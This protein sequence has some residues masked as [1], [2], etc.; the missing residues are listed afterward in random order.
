MSGVQTFFESGIRNV[1]EPYLAELE[2]SPEYERHQDE[3]RE[4]G[5]ELSCAG[6]LEGL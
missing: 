4:V 5:L 2:Y 1:S 6:W 3:H